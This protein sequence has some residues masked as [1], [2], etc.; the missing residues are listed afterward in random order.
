MRRKREIVRY[1]PGFA[2]E[3]FGSA[4]GDSYHAHDLTKVGFPTLRSAAAWVEKEWKPDYPRRGFRYWKITLQDVTPP[5]SSE[6]G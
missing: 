6:G 2:N 1:I 4:I 3:S 5:P